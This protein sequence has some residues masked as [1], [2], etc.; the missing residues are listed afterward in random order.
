MS[1]FLKNMKTNILATIT[2]KTNDFYATNVAFFFFM[3]ITTLFAFAQVILYSLGLMQVNGATIDGSHGLPKGNIWN[4]VLLTMSI[5]GCYAGFVGGILLFRGSLNF[6]YWQTTSTS[7]AII[8]QALASMWF[9]AFCSIYFIAMNV[10]RFW[11]WKNEKLEQWDWSNQRVLIISTIYL[12]TL[13]IIT[14]SLVSFWGDEIY[15]TATWMGRKNYYF[16]ATGAT[17]NMTA[18]FLMLFKSRWAFACYAIAKIFT[19]LN[20]ADAGL[21]VPIVQMILFWIMDFTGFIGWS[22]PQKQEEPIE[23]PFDEYIADLIDKNK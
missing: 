23:M 8:T 18:A 3:T 19:I 2:K 15:G 13:A 10:I 5:I 7:L 1:L 11:A 4:W 22:L 14:F 16:D 9:G 6:V 21:I 20:Y 17:L 12:L